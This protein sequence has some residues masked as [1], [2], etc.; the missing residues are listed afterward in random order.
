MFAS[1]EHLPNP[2]L[3]SRRVAQPSDDDGSHERDNRRAAI[4]ADRDG[5]G[6]GSLSELW[7]ALA[8]G[9]A[10]VV[11]TFVT[12]DRCYLLLR[13]A[14]LRL[15]R[16][17]ARGVDKFDVLA[18]TLLAGSQ[19]SVAIDLGL[20]ASSI[21]QLTKD[22]LASMGFDCRTSQTPCILVMAAHAAQR[23][24]HEPCR[25]SRISSETG[26]LRVVSVMR[27]DLTIAR[28]LPPAEC[29]VT[30]LLVEGRRRTEIAR[31]RQTSERTVANQLGAAFRR[32]RASGRLDLIRRL[33]VGDGR[34]EMALDGAIQARSPMALAH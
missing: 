31:L 11:D 9:R 20:A 33:I 16:P 10:K 15:S 3:E 26:E 21:T 32:L 6:V 28:L 5:A 27:C 4:A 24:R 18:R 13:S 14:Q 23:R 19:K 2:P 7:H 22:A 29:V 12:Q 25:S 8:G 1:Q 17:H 30:R 34:A